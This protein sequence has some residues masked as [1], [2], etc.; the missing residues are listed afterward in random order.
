MQVEG[1]RAYER[2]FRGYIVPEPGPRGAQTQGARKSLGS[3]V[4]IFWSGLHSSWEKN[5]TKFQRRPFFFFVWSSPNFGGKIGLNF[6]V[7]GKNFKKNFCATLVLEEIWGPGID[8]RTPWKIFSLRPWGEVRC[9]V[10][11][12]IL[13][14]NENP[15]EDSP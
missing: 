8:L 2:G 6:T 15:L 12:N 11:C 9:I 4:K 1:S 5:R 13:A 3:R 10:S 7:F 14:V